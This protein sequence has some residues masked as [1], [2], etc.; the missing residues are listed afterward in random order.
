MSHGTTEE[1]VTRD[2]GNEGVFALEHRIVGNLVFI[3]DRHWLLQVTVVVGMCH[4]ADN[5]T[6]VDTKHLHLKVGCPF[7]HTATEHAAYSSI[8]L[9]LSRD[10]KGATDRAVTTHL[11]SVIDADI[12]VLG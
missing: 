12:V 2:R 1:V 6:W 11:T 4:L 8:A 3:G 5:D 7:G 9:S 10:S